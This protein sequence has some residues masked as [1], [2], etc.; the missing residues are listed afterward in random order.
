ME[1]NIDI[2]DWVWVVLGEVVLNFIIGDLF[3][4]QFEVF[5]R[6]VVVAHERVIEVDSELEVSHVLIDELD[7]VDGDILLTSIIAKVAGRVVG[8][9]EV[10]LVALAL[11]SEVASAIVDAGETDIV[12]ET[13][14][15]L[16]AT[17]VALLIIGVKIESIITSTVRRG[18][19]INCTSS[20]CLKY[21]TF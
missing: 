3:E 18:I 5:I 19:A 6:Y 1:S 8:A 4:S 9:V 10:F 12:I 21:F 7:E 13:S 2:V 15:A 11:V 20:T 16:L 14:S 17:G